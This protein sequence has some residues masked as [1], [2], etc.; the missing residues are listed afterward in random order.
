MISSLRRWQYESPAP[1]IGYS[2]AVLLAAASQL[3]RIPLYPPTLMPHISYVPFVVLSAALGGFGPGLLT[4]GI[5]I[6][7]S[8]YFAT[9]PLGSFRVGDPR[10]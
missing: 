1:I 3:A 9:E 6:L 8:M 2:I 4:T 7:E 5:C 10:L